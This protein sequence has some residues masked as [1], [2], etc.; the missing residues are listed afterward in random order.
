MSQHIMTKM[1]ISKMFRH[2]SLDSLPFSISCQTPLSSERHTTFE[3]LFTE[4]KLKYACKLANYF[5][6][7]VH[8]DRL[9]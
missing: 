9:K 1:N 5:K 2:F 6:T 8:L 7:C 4:L 3:P